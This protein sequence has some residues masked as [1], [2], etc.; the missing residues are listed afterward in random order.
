MRKA[1]E[2]ALAS[3]ERR[4]LFSTSLSRSDDPK[5][6]HTAE[7]YFKD[8]DHTPPPSEKTYQVDSANPTVQRPN[9]Q[10]SGE[11]SCAGPETDEYAT[12]EGGTYDVPLSKGPEKDQ[13][14]RYG[15]TQRYYDEHGSGSKVSKPE[16]G[17]AGASAGGRKPERRS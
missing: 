11:Y 6:S 13:K 8:V 4:R 2:W 15:S 1:E 3:C 9:E 10:M 14:S 7:S 12:V 17:P 5:K 16:E